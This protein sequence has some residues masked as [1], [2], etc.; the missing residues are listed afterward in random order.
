GPAVER[1]AHTLAAVQRRAG[2][3]RIREGLPPRQVEDDVADQAR[4][5]SA[6]LTRAAKARSRSRGGQRWSGTRQPF[7]LAPRQLQV[8]PGHA[9]ELLAGVAKQKGRMKG[10][11][12][13]ARAIL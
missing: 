4:E 12:E 5:A 2:G 3:N 1:R 13:G 8:V 6:V 11:H 9:L 7:V 10:G